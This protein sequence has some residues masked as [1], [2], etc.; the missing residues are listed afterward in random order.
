M[1]PEQEDAAIRELRRLIRGGASANEILA[2]SLVLAEGYETVAQKA[3]WVY[4]QCSGHPGLEPLPDILF[5]L[6][7]LE[8]WRQ[9][10]LA[11]ARDREPGESLP[12]GGRGPRKLWLGWH[13]PEYP[14]F[15]EDAARWGFLALV[16][17]SSPWIEER[18]GR[19]ALCNYRALSLNSTLP[20]A[21]KAGRPIFAMFDHCYPD[22]RSVVSGFLGR[23]SRTP[24][25]LL[26][27]ARRF[28]YEVHVA[29]TRDGLPVV[30]DS[31][32][33]AG[34]SV[35]ECAERANAALEAEILRDP[36]RWLLWALADE[37]WVPEA[38]PISSSA[39]ASF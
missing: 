27:L 15:L 5:R 1:T 3:Q 23:P 14:L 6:R 25:G 4:R 33:P 26:H 21:L 39:P 34:L 36:P 24:G 17:R 12:E 31:F 10:L 22:S 2:R 32:D 8:A 37:R 16:P 11:A 18:I 9:F 35:E 28:G 20:R 29:S 13:F 30:L 38:S 7:H 19:E